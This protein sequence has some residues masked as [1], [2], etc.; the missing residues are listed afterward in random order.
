MPMADGMGTD[1]HHLGGRGAGLTLFDDQIDRRLLELLI[2]R[3][4]L[5]FMI[6]SYSELLEGFSEIPPQPTCP[7]PGHYWY[8][9]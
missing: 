4:P 2:K 6:L 7:G 8:V 5:R 9:Q 3:M 1:A